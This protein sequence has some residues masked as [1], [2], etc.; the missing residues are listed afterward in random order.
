MIRPFPAHW[1]EILAARDDAVMLLEALARSGCV[2]LE[3]SAAGTR[4]TPVELLRQ[5]ARYDVLAD[6]YGGYWPAA[7]ETPPA[8][9]IGR[10]VAQSLASLEAWT[11]ESAPLIERSRS[12]EAERLRLD[13]WR[14]T[15]EQIQDARFDLSRFAVAG[16]E[17]ERALFV[18]PPGAAVAVP[19]GVFA[20]PLSVGAGRALLALGLGE[21]MAALSRQAASVQGTRFELPDWLRASAAESLAYARQRLSDIERS[22]ADARERLQELSARWRLAE[23]LAGLAHAGWAIRSARSLESGNNFCRITGWTDGRRRLDAVIDASGARAL[24]HYPPP[25]AGAV[26]PLLLHNPWWAKPFEVFSRAFGT[27]ARYAA[28]PSALLAFIVPLIFGYMFGDLGQGAVL[29]AVGL[30]LRNRMPI[31]RMLVPGGV[32]AMLFGLLFG[33]V[34]GLHGIVHALWVAPLDDPLLVLGV[35]LA[36]GAVLLFLGLVINAFESYWRGKLR[37]W[38]ATDAG[39]VLVYA[40]LLAAPFD[41]SGLL[42][43]A[44][45]ALAPVAGHLALTR[46]LRPALA[47]LGVLIEHALQLLVNTLSF[48]RVGAFA[49]AHAGLSTAILSL[50]EGA[51][52]AAVRAVILVAGNAAVIVIEA[53]VVS[54][55]TTRLVLFE[56][57]TR[58]F[59]SKGRAFRPLPPPVFSEGGL[60]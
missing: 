60:A 1:F 36:G 3:A 2:E 38:L 48:V 46:R 16:R 23:A 43:A 9:E 39:L 41:R 25:P 7:A 4:E 13:V 56:F 29:V 37:H 18:L 17:V 21:T 44:L 20:L 10:M 45:G 57:F 27:P 28:D 55:Q 15:L 8:L 50:A 59:V 35:P 30:A 19:A 32:S 5:L 33:S 40:G 31:L 42:L 34:F 22:L 51:D 49:L 11:A 47:S 14:Q 12:L 24:A 6:R 53:T 54:V 52:S 26:A 58:F